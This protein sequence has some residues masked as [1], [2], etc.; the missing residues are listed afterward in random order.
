MSVKINIKNREGIVLYTEN[1]YIEDNMQITLDNSLIPQG[2]LDI[3]ENGEHIVTDYEKVNVAVA[4]SG[5]STLKKLIQQMGTA[6]QLFW[7]NVYITDLT[8]ILNYSDT[9][10]IESAQE[11]FY[12]CNMLQT[13]PEFVTSSANNMKE[14]FYGCKK[15]IEA[16]FVDMQNA[17]DT[18][19]MF[20]ECRELE[21][22]N[23]SYECKSTT[24]YNMFGYC[25]KLKEVPL[26]DTSNVISM[27]NMF[28][29]CQL[30]T[31]IPLYNT[32]NVT[33]FSSMMLYCKELTQFP[34]IDT[35]KATLM[36]SMFNGC[37]ALESL[38]P[39]DMS[40]VT[41]MSYFLSECSKFSQDLIF[42]VPNCTTYQQVCYKCSKIKKVVFKNTTLVKSFSSAFTSCSDLYCVDIDTYN[43][44]S[45]G[46]SISCL[47]CYS[48]KALV[49]RNFGTNYALSSTALSSCF[50]FEG[51]TNPTY[52][53]DGLKDGYIYIPRNMI[54]VLT[55]TT[56]WS[57][58]A[59][60]YRAL[61]DYTLDGTTTGEL[62][63]A[64]MG[65]E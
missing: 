45:T 56:N 25:Y 18:S 10:G 41:D 60:Q 50:H 34:A 28:D 57:T 24:A 44:S 37:I 61:E 27:Q 36:K 4:G 31:T 63:L 62:D 29:R 16:P 48:L 30:F 19:S 54:S 47:N 58:H 12:G 9:Q 11:M 6:Y 49:I 38:P 3:T 39:L 35:S 22:V 51:T 20:Q 17:T 2:T 32:S 21:K 46:S 15:L 1:K 64:K 7:R 13:I 65:L 53:P 42:D 5:E 52:N 26:F 8:G 14:M 55:N 40:N 33:N 59:T 23:L 43:I